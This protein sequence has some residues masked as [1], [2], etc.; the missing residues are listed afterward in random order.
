MDR[1]LAVTTAVALFAGAV[2]WLTA[3]DAEITLWLIVFGLSVEIGARA[4]RLNPTQ[5]VQK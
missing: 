4:A 5:G 2:S 1:A 3:A